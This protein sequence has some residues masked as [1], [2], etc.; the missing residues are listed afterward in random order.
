MRQPKRGPLL[1]WLA[2]PV[3]AIALGSL[4]LYEVQ[5]QPVDPAAY[6]ALA[7]AVIGALLVL[8]AWFGR[9]GGL[10]LLGF[11]TAVVLAVTAAGQPRFEGEREIDAA[12]TAAAEVLD[13]YFVP[14]GDIR[15]DLTDVEDLAALDGRTIT[16]DANA[17]DIEVVLPQGVDVALTA[18]VAVA[19]EAV[20]LGRSSN[21]PS[22][23]VVQQIDGGTGVPEVDLDVELIFGRITVTQEASQ[24]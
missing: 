20:V 18:D 8:G 4:W 5:A 16:V 11:V 14:A 13:R 19:G 9:P 21:G 1:F 23:D 6:P 24:A 3:L 7:L 12:P 22:V 10:V 2:F 17:G 15:V